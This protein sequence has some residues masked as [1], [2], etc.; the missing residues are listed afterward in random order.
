[1]SYTGKS[2][3]QA[4]PMLNYL[5]CLWK[6]KS[7]Y[8]QKRTE[9]RRDSC[10]ICFYRNESRQIKVQNT[11]GAR[12]RGHAGWRCSLCSWD[13]SEPCKTSCITQGLISPWDRIVVPRILS[14][15]FVLRSSC[16]SHL[17]DLAFDDPRRFLIVSFFHSLPTMICVIVLRHLKR[18]SLASGIEIWY[19]RKTWPS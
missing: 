12:S 14:Q 11:F 8:V 6:P 4:A 1:M 13:A 18:L 19:I 10:S 2:D 7:P 15:E 3:F 17:A 9:R 5:P 16:F